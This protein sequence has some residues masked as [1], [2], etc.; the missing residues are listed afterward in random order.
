MGRRGG[1]GELRGGGG[2]GVGEAKYSAFLLW[3]RFHYLVFKE[4]RSSV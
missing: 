4:F 2:G 3:A 1:Y